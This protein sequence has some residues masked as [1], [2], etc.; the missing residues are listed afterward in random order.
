M[1][2]FYC[3]FFLIF[4]SISLATQAQES[5]TSDLNSAVPILSKNKT[6]HTRYYYYP[7]LKAYFDT[8]TSLFIFYKNGKWLKEQQIPSGYMGYS[9]LNKRKV[10][11]ADYIGE[12]PYLLIN[13]HQKQFPANYSTKRQ[14]DTKK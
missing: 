11:I 8:Q 3:L 5:K 14:L 4:L 9:M 13:E 1:N 10:A 2:N 7:N 12:S 6:L